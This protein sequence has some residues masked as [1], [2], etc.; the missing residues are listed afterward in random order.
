MSF[1]GLSCHLSS[2]IFPQSAPGS[3][4][5]FLFPW[6]LARRALSSDSIPGV[7]AAGL[8]LKGRV[9]P[10]LSNGLRPLGGALT[11]DTELPAACGAQRWSHPGPP[12]AQPLPGCPYLPAGRRGSTSASADALL[13]SP[14]FP[15]GLN[16]WPQA[17]LPSCYWRNYTKA[18]QRVLLLNL[19]SHLL[20]YLLSWD[21]SDPSCLLGDNSVKICYW[22]R[23]Y[24]GSSLSCCG[25]RCRGRGGNVLHSGPGPGGRPRLPGALGEGGGWWLVGLWAQEQGELPP[26]PLGPRSRARGWG[27]GQGRLVRQIL[28]WIPA[29]P[30]TRCQTLVKLLTLYPTQS[31]HLHNEIT[32]SV[33]QVIACIV[34]CSPFSCFWFPFLLSSL[35]SGVTDAILGVL[36]P[37]RWCKK[38]SWLLG[39]EAFLSE[40]FSSCNIHRSHCFA[41]AFLKLCRLVTRTRYLTLITRCNMYIRSLGDL[42]KM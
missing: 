2:R 21:L 25:S 8:A 38:P 28:I 18:S 30:L 29:P 42:V 26:G 15:L 1:L 27:L 36:E 16:R 4:W 33:L 17:S 32:K 40:L 35:I 13:L 31:L 41:I 34:P 19:P 3:L 20:L 24:C 39:L 22:V 37:P 14:S 9:C 11:P 5:L 10:A 7:G 23:G 12:H 6:V